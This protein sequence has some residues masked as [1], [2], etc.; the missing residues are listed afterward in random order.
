[1]I[2]RTPVFVRL[3]RHQFHSGMG[4]SDGFA[5]DESFSDS[6]D[7]AIMGLSNCSARRKYWLSA[8]QRT[9]VALSTETECGNL[10][11][12]AK[13]VGTSRVMRVLGSKYRLVTSSTPPADISSA[14]ANSKTLS[15]LDFLPRT[16]NGIVIGK[17]SQSRRSAPDAAIGTLGGISITIPDTPPQ[18]TRADVQTF[19]ARSPTAVI[20]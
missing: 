8:V 12:L 2:R 16:K 17:R 15:P 11:L 1:M 4:S 20:T 19:S 14:F 10:A 3:L 18:I 6:D 5:A 13:A 7:P 9:T